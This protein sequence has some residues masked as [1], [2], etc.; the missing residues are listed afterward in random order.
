MDLDS[1]TQTLAQ[2]DFARL[3]FSDYRDVPSEDRWTSVRERIDEESQQLFAFGTDR[4]VRAQGYILSEREV[5]IVL[6]VHHVVCDG[7]GIFV[8]LDDWSNLYSNRRGASR[9]LFE[10]QSYLDFLSKND[11]WVKSN[12]SPLVKEQL[13]PLYKNVLRTLDIGAVLRYTSAHGAPV[14]LLENGSEFLG[15]RI[16]DELGPNP[17][18]A[19]K[20][21]GQAGGATLF[22]TLLTAWQAL[23][24]H[25][26]GYQDFSLV[27]PMAARSYPGMDKV[28]ANCVNLIPVQFHAEPDMKFAYLLNQI[29][30]FMGSIYGVMDYPNRELVLD[31]R[32]AGK[33]ESA[34][35]VPWNTT[36]NLEPAQ[37]M[38][39]FETVPVQLVS[40]PVRSVE[41]PFMMNITEVSGFLRIDIDIQL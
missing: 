3:E 19:L 21:L 17:L 23:M 25:A 29:K 41:F 16:G 33:I 2:D 15:K 9:T 39:K 26:N 12:V 32:A 11:D 35:E 34:T 20:K 13:L 30:T 14:T 1:R 38:A 6:S 28:V 36:F 37:K 7:Y 22:M 27:V 4:L 10:T 18:K 24:A 40:F 8:L 31:L 5:A